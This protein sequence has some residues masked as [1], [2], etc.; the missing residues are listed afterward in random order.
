[1]VMVIVLARPN[2][3]TVAAE[4]RESE[5]EKTG[6]F[7]PSVRVLHMVEERKREKE[8]S[9]CQ[10]VQ[11]IHQQTSLIASLMRVHSPIYI[12]QAD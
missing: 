1:M 10:S 6:K 2:Q 3:K 11:L 9:Q 4:E 5:R 12:D 8:V 7:G